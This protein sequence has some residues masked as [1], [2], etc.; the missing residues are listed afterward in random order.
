M[1]DNNFFENFDLSV[2][3]QNLRQEKVTHYK[4]ND[5][6]IWSVFEGKF[7]SSVDDTANIQEQTITLEE[8]ISALDF[9]HYPKG[10]LK[11]D[12]EFASEACAKR[13]QLLSETDY[14]V[15]PDYP[16]TEVQKQTLYSYRQAL[17]DIPAQKGFPR[18]ITWPTLNL[19]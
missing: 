15:T 19:K 9:Y 7:V 6:R 18:E 2:N 14:L 12:E 1:Y 5:G 3:F 13:N 16:L 10:E 11:S 4:L 8:L 17:R